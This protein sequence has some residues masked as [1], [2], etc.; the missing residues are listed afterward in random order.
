MYKAVPKIYQWFFDFVN[1]EIG[2]EGRGY[3]ATF[4]KECLPRRGSDFVPGLFP[5]GYITISRMGRRLTEGTFYRSGRQVWYQS[6]LSLAIIGMSK[7]GDIGKL[8]VNPDFETD[9]GSE[10]P[11]LAQITG[12]LMQATPTSLEGTDE[13]NI[14]RLQS[15]GVGVGNDAILRKAAPEAEYNNLAEYLGAWQVHFNFDIIEYF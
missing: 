13:Y 2:P 10:P 12:S 14:P 5:W 6:V 4:E 9:P 1:T 11:G 3:L 8:I 15:D 7:D